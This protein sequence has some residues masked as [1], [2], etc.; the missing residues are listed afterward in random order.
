M[1]WHSSEDPRI[2]PWP[3]PEYTNENH[4][5][6][7]CVDRHDGRAR[8]ES[9]L[10]ADDDV[11]Y[12]LLSAGQHYTCFRLR[13]YLRSEMDQDTRFKQQFVPIFQRQGRRKV[14][15]IFYVPTQAKGR[16]CHIFLPS[17]VARR[18]N[19]IFIYF[20]STTEEGG[21][22]DSLVPPPGARPCTRGGRRER[23]KE[24]DG[25]EGRGRV[26]S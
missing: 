24:A 25:E 1:Y 19:A 9:A 18:T 4:D 15:P 7:R 22:L 8:P 23:G 21:D 5:Q 2:A 12:V 6:V 3:S 13:S 20:M 17:F 16:I 10:T 26:P 11:R 14:W